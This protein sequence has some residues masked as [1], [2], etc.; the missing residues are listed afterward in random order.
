MLTSG[1]RSSGRVW[2]CS[3]A[4][5]AG[6]GENAGVHPPSR[7]LAHTQVWQDGGWHQH[8][9][10]L[11]GALTV[12]VAPPAVRLQAS[13]VQEHASLGGLDMQVQAEASKHVASAVYAVTEAR[14]QMR[15]LLL[16][17]AVLGINGRFWFSSQEI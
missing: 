7:H 9:L 16:L 14:A 2:A 4:H 1:R 8:L 10:F 13:Y 17:A 12:L 6:G 3:C 5:L 15:P 11:L